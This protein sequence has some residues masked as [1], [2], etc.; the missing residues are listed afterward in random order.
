M[1]AWVKKLHDGST[2]ALAFNRGE[3]PTTFT[4]TAAML[5]L[6]AAAT[7]SG[8]STVR[9]LWKNQDMGAF[10]SSGYT[11]AVGA[12]DVVVIR[13]TPTSKPR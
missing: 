4:F 11:A 10:G 1:Q 13:V 12:H 9:D 6:T 8:G 2:A 3:A 5:G 7:G